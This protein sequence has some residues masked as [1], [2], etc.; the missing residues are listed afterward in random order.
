M[1][2]LRLDSIRPFLRFAQR[3]SLT[4]DSGFSDMVARDF[5]IFYIAEGEG[6]LTVD[7]CVYR[8]YEGVC[9]LFPPAKVYT[10]AALGDSG[11]TLYSMNFDMTGAHRERSAP[12]PPVTREVF[13]E[14]LV[15]SPYIFEDPQILNGTVYRT[16]CRELEPRCAE[17]LLEYEQRLIYCEE[18]IS[19][20]LL[21]FI[22]LLL[23]I[24][25]KAKSSSPRERLLSFVAEN[26]GKELTNASIGVALGYHPNHLNRLSLLYTGM[27]LHKYLQ[28]YRISKATELL[29]AT[30]LSV[31]EIS[32]RVG[33]SDLAHFS[34]CFKRHTGY[35]PS[36]FRAGHRAKRLKM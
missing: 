16:D 28:T 10:V 13:T 2:G 11:M 22:T 6:S 29:S 35:T 21:S 19:A 7:G 5:R 3:F 15:L 32:V 18:R 12:V 25:C 4:R 31:D 27:S 36:A 20:C 24:D 26:Y 9:V 1:E 33:F 8:L 14:G 17:I 23:R 34:K 30:E